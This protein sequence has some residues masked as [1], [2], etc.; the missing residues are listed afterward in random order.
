MDGL[1]IPEILRR[2]QESDEA[3]R[4]GLAS[5]IGFAAIAASSLT[6][7]YVAAVSLAVLL[8]ST[9]LYRERVA[10]GLA[11]F[12]GAVA[13]LFL[14]GLLSGILKLNLHGLLVVV[15]VQGAWFIAAG[16]WLMR[17]ADPV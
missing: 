11:C 3:G 9:I 17:R 10:R 7:I 2:V 1:V 5:T 12:G 4:M 16:V 15:F 8:W 14:A 13:M 6:T